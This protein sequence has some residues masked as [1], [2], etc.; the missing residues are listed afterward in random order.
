MARY[1]EPIMKRCKALGLEPAVL[2]VFK[3]SKRN[4]KK[5]NRKK[6]EY[7][8]QLQ[9][10]QKAKF[11]YGVLEKQFRKTYQQAARL[12]GQ[13]G[14]NLMQLLERRLDNVVFRLGIADTRAQARQYVTHGHIAVNG[15]RLDIPSYTVNVGDVITIYETS[16]KLAPFTDFESPLGLP[17][18]LSM[19]AGEIRGTVLALPAREDY[20]D[21]DVK[22]TS[23]LELYSK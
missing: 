4:P 16:K 20:S 21:I 19:E 15:K 5:S 7:A 3:K 17:G 23:I 22:E 6:S 14:E 11:I 9:E 2:G 10:K 18:W 13:T 1:T 12:S 8:Q